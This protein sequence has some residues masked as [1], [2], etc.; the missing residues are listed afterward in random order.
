MTETVFDW[1][2]EMSLDDL[3]RCAK[4]RKRLPSPDICRAIREQA[5]LRQSELADALGV[6]KAAVSRWEGGSRQPQGELRERYVA[7][8]GKLSEA[9]A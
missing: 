6:S 1:G 8:I 4:R 9:V 7:A 3:V 2:E 5:G